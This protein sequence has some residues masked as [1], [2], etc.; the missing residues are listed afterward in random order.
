MNTSLLLFF[1]CLHFL[2]LGGLALYGL[3]RLWLVR[4]WT[5]ERYRPSLA[6]PPL[7][8]DPE[9]WPRVTVQLPLYNERFVARRLIDAAAHL[10]WPAS[11]LDIQV[12]D[13]SDDD[14]REIIDDCVDQWSKRG[15][16]VRI[17]SRPQRHGYKAG[18]LA[19]G[20][21]QAHGEFIAIFDA[22]FIPDPD[23]LQRTVPCF[24]DPNIGMVQTRWGF[25]NAQHNWLTGVQA[26]LLG[27]H[28]GIEHFVRCRRGLFFNFNGTAGIWRRQAIVDAGGWQSDTVTED[29]DLS[30][31]AQLVGWRF[32]Y[33]NEVVVSSELPVT[34]AAFRTQQQRW[35]KGSLQTARK[36]LP[37]V[38]R[39]SLT[40]GI[41]CEAAA[42]LLANLGWVLGALVILSLYPTIMW[43]TGIGPYQI[44]RLDLPLF[45]GSSLAILFY[46]FCY[47][48][49]QDERRLL[50][51]LPLLPLVSMGLAP[52]LGL[53][54]LAGLVRRGGVFVRT[55]K[56]G[57]LGKGTLPVAFF[58]YHQRTFLY[59]GINCLL[60]IYSLLPVQFAWQRGTWPAIPLLLVFSSGFLLLMTQ[61]LIDRWVGRVRC[62]R[63]RSGLQAEK[64]WLS[65]DS[66]G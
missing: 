26:L 59:V 29:L 9:L 5:R 57:V 63:V 16:K 54:A 21:E 52:L 60:L 66:A 61:E 37:R 25:L 42:H 13:D 3:H 43:R 47:G 24:S 53:S 55:P 34:L 19:F 39:S 44:L 64:E 35:A 58:L 32:R 30:Y 10:D 22:D 48:L 17:L 12:L 1:S 4:V 50:W 14:T 15:I 6:L 2:A 11:R 31:R 8:A 7:P 33:L 41:K 40:M 65:E 27:P 56:C 38:M 18:A 62:G 49:V 46:F 23:F 51:R 36:I 28:F 45:C 20:L